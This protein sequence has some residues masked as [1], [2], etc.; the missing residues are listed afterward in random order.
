M[1]CAEPKIFHCLRKYILFSCDRH[2]DKVDVCY[3]VTD[4]AVA[5]GEEEAVAMLQGS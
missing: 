2:G 3:T 4:F 1:F 5:G